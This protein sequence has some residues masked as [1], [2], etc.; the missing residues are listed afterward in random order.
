MRPL[1]LKLT[2]RSQELDKLELPCAAVAAAQVAPAVRL[3]AAPKKKIL[4]F[5]SEKQH[6]S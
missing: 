4:S 5:L 1:H 2:E 6:R 3:Q